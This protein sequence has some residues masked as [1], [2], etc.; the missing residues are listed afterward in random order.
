MFS[1]DTM[2]R[3]PKIL[4]LIL[5]TSSLPFPPRLILHSFSTNIGSTIFLLVDHS[6]S[7]KPRAPVCFL[8]EASQSP[9]CSAKNLSEDL[10]SLSRE[11]AARTFFFSEKQANGKKCD[12]SKY[13]RGLMLI[14]ML[15]K[16][17]WALFSRDEKL[18]QDFMSEK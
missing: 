16:D 15:D 8:F 13:V 18:P 3:S 2:E 10:L 14:R 4:F 1:E 5:T 12:L 9:F 7:P 17:N 11:A 6:I